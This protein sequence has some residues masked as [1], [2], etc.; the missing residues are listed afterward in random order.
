MRWLALRAPFDF[1][2]EAGPPTSIFPAGMTFGLRSVPVRYS[3]SQLDGY[4]RWASEMTGIVRKSNWLI[5]ELV[6]HA[7]PSSK[8]FPIFGIAMPVNNVMMRGVKL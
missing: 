2:E 4:S 5:K 6:R 1:A 7:T 8:I 3:S